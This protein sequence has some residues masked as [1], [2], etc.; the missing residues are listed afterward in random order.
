MTRATQTVDAPTA[1]PSS[2]D[3]AT[4]GGTRRNLTVLAI[5]AVVLALVAY[6][7]VQLQGT[8][9]NAEPPASIRQVEHAELLRQGTTRYDELPAVRRS[10]A[11]FGVPAVRAPAH[12]RV[13]LQQKLDEL[14]VLR[15]YLHA[16]EVPQ[17]DAEIRHLQRLLGETPGGS[18][19]CRATSP[20]HRGGVAL[21]RCPMPD[22]SAHL[23]RPVA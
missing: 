22:R 20:R 13:Q 14:R 9:V 7:V 1:L 21:A 3:T 12:Q 6:T 19:A 15:S 11:R 5:A 10:R 23:V 4:A 16:A 18:R 2:R 17:I 8:T